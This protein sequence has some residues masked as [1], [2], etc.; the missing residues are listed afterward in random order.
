MTLLG[1]IASSM[2]YSAPPPV[3]GYKLWLDAADSS[4]ITASGGDVSQWSDKS[5]FASN[6][7]QPTGA[8]QPKT[9]TRSING[10]NVIDFDG[11]NDS[12]FCASSTALFKYLHSSTGGTTF[13]VGVVDNT[14][15]DK[16]LFA[17]C[18]FASSV[19]G[20]NMQISSLE[21][22]NIGIFRGVS[23]NSTAISSDTNTLT[24]GSA[25]YLTTKFDGGNAT[26]ANRILSSLNGGAFAGF[27]TLT[28]AASSS[29]ATND[30]RLGEEP[31]GGV[32]PLDGAIGEIIIYE[33]IL[34]GPNITSVQGYL[35]AK[36]GI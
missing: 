27:N 1:I 4:Q 8:N 7:T 33:G 32:N 31:P 21:K 23:S 18:G 3:S 24:A 16:Q 34:S 13:V 30:M 12:L 19:I 6:F 22:T 14:A 15:A 35:A 5:G 9:G 17:T 25:F 28:N 26:A 11:V 20:V 2:Q 29:N 36:W 10:K